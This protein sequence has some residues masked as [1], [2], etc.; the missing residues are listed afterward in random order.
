MKGVAL[1]NHR[2][3]NFSHW[4]AIIRAGDRGG[5]L[6]S[7]HSINGGG[8]GCSC[9][10]IRERTLLEFFKCYGT[11]NLLRPSH[12]ICGRETIVGPVNYANLWLAIEVSESSWALLCSSHCGGVAFVK[13]GLQK[14][15]V[16]SLV[17]LGV[18]SWWSTRE[19]GAGA[20][21]GSHW[22]AGAAKIW[23]VVGDISEAASIGWETWDNDEPKWNLC[24]VRLIKGYSKAGL[25]IVWNECKVRWTCI[26]WCWAVS[27]VRGRI[28][29]PWM[30][31]WV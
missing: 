30:F 2:N 5:R 16:W 13:F 28:G 17:L 9:S 25:G 22:D 27:I 20:G 8:Q 10:I 6:K 31:T 29:Q 1:D 4:R 3:P 24:K 23:V 26:S 14:V 21:C 18:R 15:R 7:W 12:S 19:F 11:C